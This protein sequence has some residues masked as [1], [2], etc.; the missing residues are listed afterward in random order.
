MWDDIDDVCSE[1]R[2]ELLLHLR[3]MK[4]DPASVAIEDFPAYVS[5]LATNAC[6]H[7]FRRRRPGRAR[8]RRQ[9]IYVLR[10]EPAFRLSDGPDGRTWCE[11]QASPSRSRI[12]DARVLE[13]LAQGVEGDR[14]LATVLQ[15]ILKAAGAAVEFDALAA[16]VVRV[17]HIPPDP[18]DDSDAVDLN[19]I[20]APG[21]GAEVA[22]D[23]RRFTARLW[24]E[25]R[26][27]PRAQRVAL[28]LNL[29]VGRGN[30]ALALFT[31]AGIAAFA[32]VA[33]A[34]EVSEA[35]L[36]AIWVELPYD[37][38]RIAGL[39]GCT[40]QQVINLR[41]AARKRL[42]TRLGPER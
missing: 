30:S 41:M 20:P 25:V 22:M 40:R 29:R 11:L 23:R 16:I 6:N 19:E 9:V 5:V 32:E 21:P 8:L 37:D 1:A 39:L 24:D 35:E 12:A 42:N 18:V 28:L 10:H 4:A 34:L 7:Y 33:G 31:A 17:W 3:R 26:R 15:R 14:N 2:L 38:N 36:A 13:Q 27:L